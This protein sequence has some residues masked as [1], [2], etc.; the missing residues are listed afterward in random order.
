MLIEES[1]KSKIREKIEGFLKSEGLSLV[2]FKLFLKGNSFAVRV[3]TDYPEGGITIN[4]CARLNKLIFSYLD[5]EKILGDD[6]VVEVLSPGIDRKLTTKEDFLRVKNKFVALWLNT[7][8]EGKEYWE[9]R[10]MDIEEKD[11]FIKGKKQLLK[12][13]LDNVKFAK[14][15]LEI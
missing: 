1:K 13:P 3:I 9:G 7:P 10:L 11:L 15:K 14:Q 2:E 6:F 5:E 12:I 8:I 4:D